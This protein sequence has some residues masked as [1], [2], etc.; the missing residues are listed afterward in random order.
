MKV[1]SPHICTGEG[2]SDAGTGSRLA[3][4]CTVW[5]DGSARA[6]VLPRISAAA[7][8]KDNDIPRAHGLGE[9]MKAP[10]IPFL[11]G[12]PQPPVV[13]ASRMVTIKSIHNNVR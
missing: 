5:Q 7:S 1:P 3:E 11:F 13:G 4:P 10:G 12:F 6:W 2:Q 8:N 9:W